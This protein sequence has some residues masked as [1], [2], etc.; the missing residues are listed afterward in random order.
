MMDSVRVLFAVV[1]AAGMAVGCAGTP[2]S[3]TRTRRFEWHGAA[4]QPRSEVA[5]LRIEGGV[6]RIESVEIPADVG[7]VVLPPAVYG[8]RVEESLGQGHLKHTVFFDARPGRTYSIRR[9]WDRGIL[10]GPSE[11]K[12]YDD[13]SDPERHITAEALVGIPLFVPLAATANDAV[14]EPM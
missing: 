13:T 2:D 14:L 7:Y 8:V 12:A 1:L 4:G 5:V 6:K 3:L 9:N 10:A 11:T